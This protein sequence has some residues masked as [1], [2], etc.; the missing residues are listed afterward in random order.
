LQP[1]LFGDGLDV[2]TCGGAGNGSLG[3]KQ[4]PAANVLLPSCAP[5]EGRTDDLVEEFDGQAG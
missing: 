2:C 3:R 4:M 1:F 5:G